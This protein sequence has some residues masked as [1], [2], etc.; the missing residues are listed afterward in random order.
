MTT[1]FNT[2]A[3]LTISEMS[4]DTRTDLMARIESGDPVAAEILVEFL[5]AAV[6]K[7]TR[8]TESMMR[9]P[10]KKQALA[11]YILDEMQAA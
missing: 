9:S 5:K 2:L 4:A 10:T 7:N 1:E 6:A 8:I 3:A 11:E